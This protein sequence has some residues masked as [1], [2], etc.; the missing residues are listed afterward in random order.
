MLS[1]LRAK[2]LDQRFLRL[3]QTLLQTG[4]LEDWHYHA[5][6]SGTPQGAIVS[7]ILSKLSL[8]KLDK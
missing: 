3:I 7:P 2:I 4:Y 6:L 5:T 8:D 1:I